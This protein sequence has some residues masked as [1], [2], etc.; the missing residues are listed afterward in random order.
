[1][2]LLLSLLLALAGLAAPA[3]P[4][5]AAP[6]AD[7][8]AVG[9]ATLTITAISSTTDLVIT[10]DPLFMDPE[11]N[12][13][14]DVAT[15]GSGNHDALAEASAALNAFDPFDVR[16]GDSLVAT[17]SVGGFVDGPSSSTAESSS[18]PIIGLT[19]DNTASLVPVTVSFDVSYS[20]SA[21]AS[22]QAPASQNALAYADVFV[23]TAVNPPFEDAATAD[24]L[25]GDP[26][27]LTEETVSFVLPVGAGE[28][29]QLTFS[30][31]A[32]GAADLAVPEPSATALWLVGALTLAAARRAHRAS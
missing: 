26:P 28:I 15:D 3:P 18:L 12:I 2:R 30:T 31:G 6:I 1:M 10:I 5:A 24:T 7:Y 20:L 27:I 29:G 4:A 22:A 14:E 17:A 21:S 19:M 32:F 25:E 9:T 16:V 11:F 8:L 23:D 13:I